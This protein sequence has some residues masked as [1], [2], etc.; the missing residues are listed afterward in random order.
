MSESINNKKVLSSSRSRS[1]AR[2]TWPPSSI[3]PLTLYVHRYPFA[4]SQCVV[5][6]MERNN[7]KRKKKRA[8]KDKSKKKKKWKTVSRRALGVDVE[9][10]LAKC[11][12]KKPW[13][14][15]FRACPLSVV[16]PFF[17]FPSTVVVVLA[18][19]HLMSIPTTT[20]PPPLGN[21]TIQPM[22]WRWRCVWGPPPPPP[23]RRQYHT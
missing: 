9:G 4:V 6:S 22:R 2:R 8:P 13:L 15:Y 7:N 20:P 16:A 12:C 3:P 11:T 5:M 19:S 1:S 14:S 21:L 23:P 10:F 18:L 17:P